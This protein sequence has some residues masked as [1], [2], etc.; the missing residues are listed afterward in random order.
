MTGSNADIR[1]VNIKGEDSAHLDFKVLGSCVRYRRF[2][3]PSAPSYRTP[4]HAPCTPRA[5]GSM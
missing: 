4:R 5:R 1:T 2:Q 3:L